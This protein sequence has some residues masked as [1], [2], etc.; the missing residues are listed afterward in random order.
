L[1]GEEYF[2]GGR[3]DG[4]LDYPASEPVLRAEFRRTVNHLLRY[5]NSGGRL[6]EIGCAYGFFLLEA[7]RHFVSTGIEVSEAAIAECRKR[8]LTVF[9]SMDASVRD[10]GPFDVAVLL[11]CIEHL[12]DPAEMLCEI[13]RN[14]TSDGVVLITT[15]DWGSTLARVT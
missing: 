11:D 1:Y 12:A 6:L 13:R 2:R 9:G 15:G 14:L 10:R 5:V 3:R 7:Q 8:G 4:Y